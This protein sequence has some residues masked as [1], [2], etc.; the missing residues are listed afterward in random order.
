M[1]PTQEDVESCRRCL[2][3]LQQAISGSTMGT[4]D[5]SANIS[6]S[7]LIGRD[8]IESDCSVYR[9]AVGFVVAGIVQRMIE[10]DRTGGCLLRGMF[11][12]L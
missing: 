5:G 6:T 12:R 11:E 7:S 10:A 9:A 1:K 8:V 2:E 3:S 4:S